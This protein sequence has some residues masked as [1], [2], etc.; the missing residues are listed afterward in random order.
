MTLSSD[1]V[2]R[3]AIGA[4][5]WLLPLDASRKTSPRPYG[6]LQRI[7][8]RLTNLHE[9]GLGPYW[10]QLH[11]VFRKLLF[12]ETQPIRC[13]LTDCSLANDLHEPLVLSLPKQNK[14]YL[15][16]IATVRFHL[17]ICS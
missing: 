15:Y 3:G 1:Y 12:Y 5:G 2:T 13:L 4:G 11:D 14:F 6:R 9:P 17:L 10:L 16:P 8:L 7:R